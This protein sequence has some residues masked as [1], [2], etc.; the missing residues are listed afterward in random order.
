MIW[1]R[2]GITRKQ[3][4][5]LNLGMPSALGAP[6]ELRLEVFAADDE[7]ASQR[8]TGSD[9]KEARGRPYEG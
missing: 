9:P 8:K 2:P 6:Q 1:S 4:S 5:L 7:A 3:R